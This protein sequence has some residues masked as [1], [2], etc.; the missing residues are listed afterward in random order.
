[1]DSVVIMETAN[2]VEN[3]YQVKI[4]VRTFFE[5]LTSIHFLALYIAQHSAVA[6]LPAPEI[7]SAAVEAPTTQ[8]ESLQTSA[9]APFSA[10]ASLAL[11]KDVF[12]QQMQLMNQQIQ[13]LQ[14]HLNQPPTP[15]AQAE[16][17]HASSRVSATVPSAEAR[18]PQAP[19]QGSPVARAPQ[20]APVAGRAG[21]AQKQR[22]S[23][24]QADYLDRFIASYN[25]RHEKSKRQIVKDRKF[26][27]DIRHST[28]FRSELKEIVYPIVG[29]RSQGARVVDIDGNEYVDL[30]LGMGV[31]FF[32]HNPPFVMRAL[33]TQMRRGMHLGVYSDLAGDVAAMIRQLTG[34]ER[35][36]FCNS[37]TEAVM[38]ALRLARAATGRSKVAMFSVAYHGHSDGTLM[39]NRRTP[40]GNRS[41]PWTLGVPL[42]Y[43]EDTVVLEYG[44]QSAL[45][46]IERHHDQLAAVIV[47]PVQSR[48]PGLQPRG[49]LQSLQALAKAHGIAL[50]FDEV[51]TGFRIG[52]GGAKAWFGIE[53]DLVTY[54]KLIGG[55]MPVGL[56][57][58]GERFMRFIDG[59]AWEFGDDSAP[60][61]ELAFAAGTFRKHPLA[62]ASVK[63]V[64]EE[65]I[66]GGERMYERV[67][68]NAERLIERINR[69]F[70]EHRF[71][72]KVDGF[73]SLFRFA[74]NGNTSYLYQPLEMDLFFYHL[75]QNGVY[76]WEGRTCFL[77]TEH[78]EQELEAIYQAV[79]S[80]ATALREGGF[81]PLAPDSPPSGGPRGETEQGALAP[82]ERSA[83]LS[84]AQQ[85]LLALSETTADGTQA[86]NVSITLDIGGDTVNP[87]RL[88]QSIFAVAR[89]HEAMRSII[90]DNTQIVLGEQALPKLECLNFTD[91]PLD[92]SGWFAHRNTRGFALDK[93]PLIR[94]SLLTMAPKQY[95]FVVTAH[96]I[97]FDGW[98]IGVCIDEILKTYRARQSGVALALSAPMQFIDYQQCSAQHVLA[99][100]EAEFAFWNKALPASIPVLALPLANSGGG[101][102]GGS[103]KGRRV[104]RT[105]DGDRYRQIKAAAVANSCTLYIYLFAVFAGYLHR[106]SA[107]RTILLGTP[108]SG[109]AGF[110]QAES[111]VG[112]CSHLLPLH[113]QITPGASMK[114]FIRAF[115]TQVL[116]AME[117]QNYPYADLLDRLKAERR[118]NDVEIIQTVF[119]MER[120]VK[121]TAIDGLTIAIATPEVGYAPFGISCNVTDTGDSFIVDLDAQEDVFDA[122]ALTRMQTYLQHFQDAC[123]SDDS[124]D[125]FGLPVLPAEERQI[126]ARFQ[127]GEVVRYAG[128]DN[129]VACI[130]DQARHTPHRLAVSYADPERTRSLSYA[131]LEQSANRIAHYLLE[132]GAGPEQP[133]GVF[134]DRSLELP[135]VLL[136]ILKAGAA[137]V[138][139]D[140][141][142]P[143]SRIDY[144]LRDCRAGVVVTQSWLLARLGDEPVCEPLLIDDPES[145]G[146]ARFPIQTPQ[147]EIGREQLAYIIYTSGST[148]EP[149]GVMVPHQGVLNRLQWMQAEYGL[150][151]GDTV[152]QKTPYS[153]DVSVWE[154]FW[155]LMFGARLLLAKPEGHKDPA[156]LIELIE[157][158]QVTTIHFVPSMLNA[159]LQTPDVS[160]CRSLIRLFC[161]GEAISKATEQLCLARLPDT[162]LHNLYGPTEASVD[163]S[164]WRCDAAADFRT[165]PIGRPIANTRLYVLDANLNACP[166]GAV[167][168]LY[169]SG[170]GLAR[171]YLNRDD[172]T[173]TAFL[174]N[175]HWR[176]DAEDTGYERLYKTGD[177]ACYLGDG[178]IE[179]LGRRDQ[180][181]KVRGFR[182]ELEEIEAALRGQ[183]VVRDAAVLAVEHAGSTALH[184]YVVADLA[185][186]NTL[187]TSTEQERVGEW[188]KIFDDMYR[189]TA[190]A[191]ETFDI[192]GWDSSYTLEPLPAQEMREWLDTTVARIRQTQPRHVLEIGVGTGL[193][194]FPL[195]AFCESYRGFDVSA[196]VI[197]KLQETCERRKLG[198]VRLLQG[199]AS[200]AHC[201]GGPAPDT[202]ILNSVAQSFPS[203]DYLQAVLERC[204]DLLAD[205]GR[206]FVGDVRHYDLL[207]LFH[208][209]VAIHQADGT[210]GISRVRELA[211]RRANEDGELSVSPHYFLG[212]LQDHPAVTRLDIML[213]EGAADNELTKY[214]YDVIVEAK[215]RQP[216]AAAAH[217]ADT[218]DVIRLPWR[219][220]G[221]QEVARQ[222][223][224][225]RAA[226][227]PLFVEAAPNPRLAHDSACH[228]LLSESNCIN[229]GQL[230][231]QLRRR[232]SEDAL[233]ALPLP[234]IPTL[235]RLAAEHGYTVSF[236]FNLIE[237]ACIDLL[238]APQGTT[239]AIHA[240]Q[241]RPARYAVTSTSDP[242]RSH[243]ARHLLPLW[244]EGLGAKLPE[245]MVPSRFVLL[246]TLPTTANGKLDRKTL[247]ELD[248]G[249]LSSGA[250]IP[251][252]SA[253]EKQLAEIWQKLLGCDRVSMRDNFYEIGG[254][255]I[256]SLQLIAT[257]AEQG[258]HFTARQ[259]FENKTIER[260]LQ[261]LADD[262]AAAK[263]AAQAV[264]E[265]QD[266]DAALSLSAADMVV[267]D[268]QLTHYRTDLERA[269]SSKALMRLSPLQ[270]GM[271]YHY[272]MAPE[273]EQYIEQV[274]LGFAQA[275]SIDALRDAWRTVCGSHAALRTR[276]FWRGLSQ[277]LQCVLDVDGSGV[278]AFEH[279]R[280]SGTVDRQAQMGRERSRGFD[281]E[282]EALIRLTVIDS[283]EEPGCHLLWTFHHIILDAWSINILSEEFFRLY[284][285][286]LQ[287][288]ILQAAAESFRYG[289]YLRELRGNDR[290]RQ[291][292]FWRDYLRSVETPCLLLE[293]PAREAGAQV[294]QAMGRFSPHHVQDILQAARKLGVQVNVLLQ[295]A[296]SLL[297]SLYV[298]NERVT[299]GL[300]VSGRSQVMEQRDKAVGLFI[301]TVP[302]HI[303]LA[304]LATL[305]DVVQAM[306]GNL[307]A[308]L[309]HEGTALSDIQACAPGG[310]GQNL[311]DCLV[312]VENTPKV[313][314]AQLKTAFAPEEIEFFEKTNYP[315]ELSIH[316]DETIE[317][318]AIF[319][320]QRL[321][322]AM[323]ERL[324]EQFRRVVVLV[325][326]SP[327][328]PRAELALVA[329]AE[330]RM[331]QELGCGTA[332]T[333]SPADGVLQRFARHCQATPQRV[334]VEYRD[335][336][337]TYAQLDDAATRLAGVIR[338]S[339]VDT[340]GIYLPRS[341]QMV[342]AVLAS[343]KAGT[344]FIPIDASLPAARIAYILDDADVGLL[345]ADG[346][347]PPLPSPAAGH[348][349]PPTVIDINGQFIAH[350]QADATRPG[351]AVAPSDNERNVYTIYTSGS[352]G[353]P[354]GVQ[355]RAAALDNFL[356]GM[357]EVVNLDC[358]SR[359]LA[360]TAISFDIA[361]LELL[362]PL[363]N[364]ATVV[365]AEQAVA[366]DGRALSKALQERGISHMQA[367]PTTWRMLLAAG[368][369]TLRNLT[370]LV[371]GDTLSVGL[372][373]QLRERV[374]CLIN[375]YGPTETTIWSSSYRID[376]AQ[377]GSVPIGRAILNTQL[378]VLDGQQRLT[379][380]G[381]IGE[382]YIGGAG[383]ALGYAGRADLTA[384]RF[385]QVALPG[386]APQ[387]LYRTGDRVRYRADGNLEYIG[388]SDNQIKLNGYRIELGEIE[389]A[390]NAHP[391]IAESCVLL[392]GGEGQAK[393]LAYLLCASAQAAR[394]MD[395]AALHRHLSTLLP[396]YMWPSQVHVCNDFP[397]NTNRKTD[398]KALLNRVRNAAGT[399]A[400]NVGVAAE[401]P[402]QRLWERVLKQAP[403]AADADFFS[404]GGNS[405][406]AMELLQAVEA[407][408]AVHVG[409]T[410]FFAAP[411]VTGLMRHVSAGSAAA[412][413]VDARERGGPVP[414][415][416]AQR[417]IWLEQTLL[418]YSSA[419]NITSV[420]TITGKL[421]PSKMLS[422]IDHA[423][424]ANEA[425]G[426]VFSEGEEGIVQEYQVSAVPRA[427][428]VDWPANDFLAGGE[429]LP[430]RMAASSFVRRYLDWKFDLRRGP[431]AVVDLVK[432]GADRHLL[433]F[434]AHH[435]VFDGWSAN[436]L[437]SQIVARYQDAD[438]TPLTADTGFINYLREQP[439]RSV[440]H[441]AGL[442]FWSDWLRGVTPFPL[443][444]PA[445][446][447][448]DNDA[449]DNG[450][451]GN[452]SCTA[453]F[454]F[455][456][457]TTAALHDFARRRKTSLF[458]VL[459][460]AYQAFLAR[461]GGETGFAV[462]T[463]VANRKSRTAR[464][465]VGCLINTLI[466]P[467]DFTLDED[468]AGIVDRLHEKLRQAH[469]YD[470]VPYEEVLQTLGGRA[471][472]WVNTLF[473]LEAE[474]AAEDIHIP[475]LLVRELELRA[476]QAK[477]DLECFVVEEQRG[478]RGGFHYR[479]RAFQQEI[480]EDWAVCFQ[481]FVQNAIAGEQ[482][483]LG[484]LDMV[485]QAPRERL[486]H[487]WNRTAREF[488]GDCTLAL[489]EQRVKSHPNAVA[490]VFQ[491]ERLSYA[492]LNGRANQL[493][494]HLIERGVESG[495]FVGMC[496][497]RSPWM[498]LAI[499][500]IWKAGA[501]YVPLDPD[502][503]T[504][505][506]EYLLRDSAAALVLTQTAW[507]G[508]LT[509]AGGVI[510]LDADH[511]AWETLDA[512]DL[513][514]P[515][516][517]DSLAY[518]LY[519]SGSTGQPKGVMVGH[520]ALANRLHWMQAAYPIDGGDVVLQKTPYT[521]DVSVWEF[522]WPLLQGATLCIAR[523]DGHKDPEYLLDLIA[524]ERVTTLHFVPSMLEIFL[525]A[526]DLGRCAGI[527]RIF[528]SGEA[529]QKSLELNCLRRLPHVLLVNLY[530]PTEA[531]ID[532]SHW[533]CDGD[534]ESTRVPIGRPIANIR[535]YVLDVRQQLLPPGAAGELCIG[536]VGLAQG[537]R[538]LPE[539]TRE[540]FIADPYSGNPG[541]RLYRTGDL[542]RFLHDGNIEYLCRLDD[543]IKLRGQRIEPGEIV[544]C[545][546][547][548]PGVR[549]S[550]VLAPID[551]RGQQQL[552]A[553]YVS[554]TG[555]DQQSMRD[556]LLHR[557]PD[558][559]VPAVWVNLPALPLS[560]NGKLDKGAL[561]QPSEALLARPPYQAPRSEEER[562]LADIWSAV[563]GVQKPGVRDNF[564]AS[565]GDSIKA[566]QVASRLRKAL[567]T[568][569]ELRWVFQV[570]DL[571]AMAALL[572][573][574]SGR[575][576][577]VALSSRRS[578]EAPIP[579]SHAQKRLWF[580]SE[581]EPDDSFYNMA[582]AFELK[583]ADIERL[584][585]AML[586]V[587]NRHEALRTNISLDEQ[588]IP[589]QLIR[590]PLTVWPLQTIDA[591]E[592]ALGRTIAGLV[593]ARFDFRN[594]PLMKNY[595][596]RLPQRQVVLT[597]IHHIIFDGWSIEIFKN[598]VLK[599]Y[600]I[601]G[602]ADA[603]SRLVSDP[604]LSIQ[605]ADYSIWQNA[606][607]DSD[608]IQLEIAFWKQQLEG[609]GGFQLPLDFPRPAEMNYRGDR[610]PVVIAPDLVAKVDAY[611]QE[612]ASEGGVTAFVCLLAAYQL[613]MYQ[614]SGNRDI[615]IGTP[616]ANR[617]SEELE[618]L[619]GFFVNM[620][621][622]RSKINPE[623]TFDEFVAQVGASC[624]SAQQYQNLPFEM[625]IDELGMTRD[626]DR[627]PLFQHV[628][629]LQT[630]AEL[631]GNV[632]DEGLE[633]Q[634]GLHE[635]EIERH[636][637]L[638]D[639]RMELTRD[640]KRISGHFEYAATL[641]TRDSME[642][643]CRRYQ[644]LL[645]QLLSSPRVPLKQVFARMSGFSPTNKIPFLKKD[646]SL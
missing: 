71:P 56:V 215:G 293:H 504:S 107:Q 266:A 550:A 518:M 485:A 226:R 61:S 274:R 201:E 353:Q 357:D 94:F 552:V 161:S 169:I 467:A 275:L 632:S 307:Q 82:S 561:P 573:R 576:A 31:H 607:L 439:S 239:L 580:L 132:R 319:D 5:E 16:T 423:I 162:E 398:R 586:I 585:R 646:L 463:P 103:Y 452:E 156:Y 502:Y 383:L 471:G 641:F 432:V 591:D 181:V 484:L 254:D 57:A 193:L 401:S 8:L 176:G 140:V 633:T 475:G 218:V 17:P 163:V 436:V 409:V 526:D 629:V 392:D 590:P 486:L 472:A 400:E 339:A 322:P 10:H 183:I 340:V 325:G 133:V 152:L 241:T 437:L 545:I 302:V 608:L 184:A 382:L 535:L 476:T 119:N 204:L 537:Y 435:L 630:T 349:A 532:V 280:V 631:T 387:R 15:F 51:I 28:G 516:D 1:M 640:G 191:E 540:K 247:R 360:V 139:I 592:E 636:K 323:V 251:P 402:M 175:P 11:V 196:S 278:A 9:S 268:D 569:V 356:L 151:A 341:I 258:I 198:H 291:Q 390:L 211:K 483:P 500:A 209:S 487:D 528:C 395:L 216:R 230:R 410:D 38:T 623:A 42:S 368:C 227:S 113:S 225:L 572:A 498:P 417:R 299:Y 110:A 566:M 43:A 228:Q 172:L 101:A 98:S 559:M 587:V 346:A 373:N 455:D 311:F 7:K 34:M 480:M 256:L 521:F 159:F 67:N 612:R 62:M 190:A 292:R 579:L 328:M 553:Y 77:S 245:Y 431:L 407:Q 604:P 568:E 115:R 217:A 468:F 491:G 562:V 495:S 396:R 451:S 538:N 351:V 547:T 344:A 234:D 195:A 236:S 593:D 315:F 93:P 327:E 522:I 643:L 138:P 408:Y 252:V 618:A 478:L 33:E 253:P 525:Q 442:R 145:H 242:A 199:E 141:S 89:R 264:G 146:L 168:E 447:M 367:T 84:R 220:L 335:T 309:E 581:M 65:I 391:D 330:A 213:K 458:V 120:T 22:Y 118:L 496:L 186:A 20:A 415:N 2:A 329:G 83:A 536:G 582:F 420:V 270:Q 99:N 64:L 136:G 422:A 272:R 438:L 104:T 164:Y 316:V 620:L 212:F 556:H 337:L 205:G 46:A 616:T 66:R 207:D 490:V 157:A 627:H 399:H 520:R 449:Q 343:I 517:G 19:A 403:I 187:P 203:R 609:Y 206:I 421:S 574:R 625:L 154:F 87:D 178:N 445:T 53:P 265:E 117:H 290:D 100:G 143:Q 202:I 448:Q 47:E 26:V 123:L 599:Y 404:L 282:K 470:D 148:G 250:Y 221:T 238:F 304:P 549:E 519:T 347:A 430:E 575:H 446:A 41:A 622:L 413:A 397:L 531:A 355:V 262:G 295:A 310:L 281:L 233:S 405:M 611:I 90:V 6:I 411:T 249:A 546:N 615:C 300:S 512:D 469:A 12:A 192:V 345:I 35:S 276:I 639:T 450:K 102:N 160:R 597:V 539:L 24:Q 515:G 55:G 567:N 108:V 499:L 465:I 377:E 296:W 600:R 596:V 52:T 369:P 114:E 473:T 289:D 95:K 39:I 127:Q 624:L 18:K 595:L 96:H 306:N 577:P 318:V 376:T 601:L 336:S 466:I 273:D 509:A 21:T 179:Y 78:G 645:E 606:V 635:L 267:L 244:R 3:R 584:K 177:L 30:A 165:V 459:M 443:G 58:G 453:G 610:F 158:Q 510:D 59:G 598:E 81:F 530:G 260:L 464:N 533:V 385:V 4:G 150:E 32:G 551:A 642:T 261:A 617:V 116:E 589:I 210:H 560:R 197:A 134:M 208:G 613:L 147:A 36:A 527:R 563:L 583:D 167:G 506:L 271:L 359:L 171:G 603:E 638:F 626:I 297:L 588:G 555:L 135:A 380:W 503:P 362:L 389:A 444:A 348:R 170:V 428:F 628:F 284:L 23:A 259:L 621:A 324:L 73:G 433:C 372:A 69:F 74:Q 312:V 419:H 75:V 497:R 288:G 361:Y 188:S 548:L 219:T 384:E 229:A 63:A 85:Q 88:K 554:D 333:L 269:L 128:A 644:A 131:E 363:V 308:V 524:A 303:D 142:L 456:G 543:Q 79:V 511:A 86:Y 493:A 534:Q 477:F 49:F 222:L 424:A 137:Y 279:I 492:Q 37:G 153:F 334:A 388:R 508:K 505:R 68:G 386:T 440:D 185:A 557:L 285:H 317:Y 358:H 602:Q 523:P 48:N 412:P 243:L 378:Y 111:V 338:Q 393:L 425:F 13:L 294:R 331:L 155:P 619:I 224:S 91:R 92:A 287:G 70:A 461:L 180:Q 235:Q 542:A 144:I 298:G 342:V 514:G 25:Q 427:S 189:D 414:V 263:P 223:Q 418:P 255:S 29:D 72:I 14:G 354:K 479:S 541:D 326:L 240:L 45:D 121:A 544:A 60:D 352:T 76:M 501:A 246:T 350:A 166:V 379:P 50:I 489:I 130:A 474:S 513:P 174:D 375:L 332:R 365:V 571:G 374:G 364:G 124:A 426:L 371:G 126:L 481:H 112:Y 429:W 634:L 40:E 488:D 301:N 248:S 214:R 507:L 109:R 54:G 416:P 441:A 366:L 231:E 381:R 125:L 434:T 570:A 370:A 462:A 182:V 283:S 578:C 129:I 320:R 594:D 194:L 314:S 80:S 394:S 122:D 637:T 173:R 313:G 277:P 494:R 614:Y 105:I 200:A 232:A 97:F 558:Y 286:K 106:M 565:G 305:G 44:Q 529:L 27:A 454:A 257:C 457:A 460:A 605:Y 321:A 482:R 237:P 406:L 564:F 149:K